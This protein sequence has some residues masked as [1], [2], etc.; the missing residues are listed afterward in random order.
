[1]KFSICIPNYN[2]A[3]YIGET[4]ES[5]RAQ[6][7][8]VEI[9]VSDNCSTDD[10]VAVV[11]AFDDPRIKLRVNSWNVGFA[12]N[13]DRACE[14]AT[15][16]RMLLLSSDDLARSDAL[17]SYERL[18][19]A[20]GEAADYAIF[21]AAQIVIDGDG[22][23][24]GE[25]RRDMRLWGGCVHD[26]ALSEAVGAPVYRISAEE[27][28]RKSLLDLRTPLPFASTCYSRE[29]YLRVEGYAGWPLY[30]P[31]KVFLWKLLTLAR[32]VF[33]IDKP[34]FEYRF[35]QN[36]QAAQESQ[37]GALKHLT[38]QYR[39][40]FDIAP[41]TLARASLEKADLARAFVE[42]DI[43]LR[44]L[45]MVAEGSRSL[46]RR[47]LDFGRAAYPDLVRK[48]RKARALKALLAMGPLGTVMARNA[49]DRALARHRAGAAGDGR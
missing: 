39:A 3:R 33:F 22:K 36:N 20:L 25:T 16:D 8:D 24:T 2:Y 23:P 49:Y 21:G 45:K 19:A 12:G 18:A 6:R 5:A 31:D 14:G 47:T 34:L 13:L 4:I 11:E 10:S 35:H 48:S 27:L 1:M 9:L 30:N 37:S 28:L 26:A 46:A 17:S 7:A 41:E 38:D 44:G 43:A 15:G 40:T 29:L 32:E 42:Q